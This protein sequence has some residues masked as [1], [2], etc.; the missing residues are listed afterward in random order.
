MNLISFFLLL[1]VSVSAASL[2]NEANK[3]AEN[4]ANSTV[5]P[6]KYY[7]VGSRDT[8]F[9]YLRNGQS[10]PR[11]L[12][13]EAPEFVPV[14][15]LQPTQESQHDFT[16]NRTFSNFSPD[17]DSNS[18]EYFVV[19]TISPS[20]ISYDF[21]NTINI[22]PNG[23]YNFAPSPIQ[24]Q[25]T[26][27][28]ANFFPAAPSPILTG[29]DK[30]FSIC[31]GTPSSLGEIVSFIPEIKYFMNAVNEKH[32]SLF[33]SSYVLV[34]CANTNP[35]E[36]ESAASG[37]MA[38]RVKFFTNKVSKVLI[39][40]NSVLADHKLFNSI[41]VIYLEFNSSNQ[42]TLTLLF[43]D[44]IYDHANFYA[45]YIST[46]LKPFFEY[47]AHVNPKFFT[48]IPFNIQY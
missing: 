10:V 28:L 13:S 8:V 34:P 18:N 16:F 6:G 23:Y 9:K 24:V 22:N 38:V 20:P 21:S 33:K 44:H 45:S 27:A 14:T 15:F 48:W 17:L 11:P 40:L 37:S 42:T 5:L 46:A 4:R 30:S 32:L 47:T 25:L 2:N 7:S 39:H 1:V 12:R 41:R 31:R 36:V 19:P 35:Y 29:A 3:S 43:N 26:P